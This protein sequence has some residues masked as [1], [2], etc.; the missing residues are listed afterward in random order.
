MAPAYRR[1]IARLRRTQGCLTDCVA[2]WFGIHPERVPCFVY[3][4][5]GWMDRLRAYF[6]RRGYCV[7]WVK[8]DAPPKR[9]THIVCGD[10]LVW[11][12]YAHVVVYRNGKLVYDPQYPS[13]WKDSRITHRLICKRMP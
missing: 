7:W 1:N 9:G 2:F 10:S 8:C 5:K 3:P 6:R 11:K 12:T 13:L 4:R